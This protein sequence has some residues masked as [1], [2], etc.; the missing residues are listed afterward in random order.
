MNSLRE[1]G[2]L[3]KIDIHQPSSANEED[4]LRVHTQEHVQ[5][6]KTFTENG[7]GYLDFDT[8]ASPQSYEIAKLAAGGAIKASELILEEYDFAYSLA[9]PPGHHAT[10]NRAMGFC[11]IN[12][13]AVAI[14]YMMEK[15]A[16]EKFFILILMLIMETAL[17]RYFTMTRKFFTSQYTKTPELFFLERDL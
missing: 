10:P 8:Y 6:L 17:Q 15:Y 5:N 12:N 3:D 14:K 1:E 7:G 2:L 13:L 11:L 9:R 16:L 4:I